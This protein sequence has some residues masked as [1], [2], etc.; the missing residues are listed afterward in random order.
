MGH[1]RYFYARAEVLH[2]VDGDTI[3]VEITWHI[4][5]RITCSTVQ[6]LRVARIN[7]PE[8]NRR[9]E[10]V[11][12]KAAEAHL[13]TL[14]RERVATGNVDIN[15]EPTHIPGT[16]LAIETFKD[17]GLSRYVADIWAHPRLVGTDHTI[18]DHLVDEG[19]AEYRTY[20]KTPGVPRSKSDSHLLEFE[21]DALHKLMGID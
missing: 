4:G 19:H 7:T 13:R 18:N 20:G 12:G 1:R 21:I 10:M 5:F 11:A 16:L 15:G 6:R 3:D 9:A 14:I 8:T 17:D 2:I